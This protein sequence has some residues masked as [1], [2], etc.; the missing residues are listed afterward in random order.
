MPTNQRRDEWEQKLQDALTAHDLVTLTTLLPHIHAADL[1]RLFPEWEQEAQQQVLDALSDEHAAELLDE[2][3]P[4]DRAQ[5]LDLLSVERAS[6]IIE[7][8]PSDEA[9][10]LLGELPP[11]EADALLEQMEPGAA[12]DIAD[13]LRYPEDT[14]GGLMVKEF[15][16]LTPEETTA[17]VLS[18]LRSHQDDAEMI[19]CLYVLDEDER[20]LGLVTLRDLIVSMPD[21]SMADI[22]K[23]DVES[24]PV[25]MPQDEVAEVVRRHDLL[26]VPVLDPAG[27]ML[28]L[29]TVDDIGDV[30][31]E[32]AAEELLTM[33]GSE[34]TEE[35]PPLFASRGWRNGLL[36][37]CGGLLGAILILGIIQHQ[38][39]WHPA[40]MLLPLLT[41]IS[42]IAGSQA[43]ISMD[44]AYDNAVE[45]RQLERIFQRELVT[46]ALLALLGGLL[47]GISEYFILKHRVS[48]ALMSGGQ[49]AVGLWLAS[50]TGAVGALQVRRRGGWLGTT[51]HTLIVVLAMLIAIAVYLLLTH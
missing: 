29:V 14:A 45:S 31:Q 24:V 38:P 3:E 2:L 37:L 47:A 4:V 28:G 43:A 39:A 7:E 13:L 44:R 50:I 9:A 15:V 5:A 48:L 21:A 42:L 19:Y 12:G 16:R 27:R 17:E 41:I 23:H 22:M 10:D 36:A 8:M 25:D 26:A 30:V 51:T 11:A 46:G 6:D 40:A 34:E 49:I 35:R 1:A 32:E 20:L 18:M 33:G